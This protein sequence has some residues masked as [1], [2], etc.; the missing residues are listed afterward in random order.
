MRCLC[1]RGKSSQR[2]TRSERSHQRVYGWAYRCSGCRLKGADACRRWSSRIIQNCAGPWGTHHPRHAIEL[3]HEGLCRPTLTRKGGGNPVLHGYN[4]LPLHGGG[5]GGGK[6]PGLGSAL[7]GDRD[8]VVREQPSIR[9]EDAQQ[10]GASAD[11]QA[12]VGLADIESR[13]GGV[14]LSDEG[15]VLPRHGFTHGGLVPARAHLFEGDH[16]QVVASRPLGLADERSLGNTAPPVGRDP[17]HPLLIGAQRK[18]RLAPGSIKKERDLG[19][20]ASKEGALR[21]ARAM[22][23]R[24]DRRCVVAVLT[25]LVKS[26]ISGFKG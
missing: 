13:L 4:A 15:G 1:D 3:S 24:I 21:G 16:P 7:P 8:D 18:G 25:D 6:R 5:L 2:S 26:A 20:I 22:C 23:D 11:R 12:R 14:S 9:V 19:G 17:G 10:Q